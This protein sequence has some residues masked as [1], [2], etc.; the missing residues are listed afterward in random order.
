MSCR[1]LAIIGAVSITLCLGSFAANSG[2]VSVPTAVSLLQAGDADEAEK[3]LQTITARE[4]KNAAAW[5]YLG[6]ARKA[7]KAWDE[8]ITAYR[9]AIE[10]DPTLINPLYNLAAISALKGDTEGAFQWLGKAKATHKADLTGLSQDNDFANVKADPRFASFLPQPEDFKN[11]FVEDV[12]IIHEFDG[13]GANDQFGWIAR[14]LGDIDGDGIADFVTSAPNNAA[15]GENAGAIYVYSSRRGKLLW[16]AN[17]EK[18]D[19]LGLGVECA[20]DT[21]GDGI[22]DVV[23]SSP[24]HGFAHIY[25][26]KDGSTLL[27]VKSESAEPEAFGQ[28]VAG[29]GDVNHD[30]Y[31]DFI[32][33]APPPPNSAPGK[34]IGHAYVYSG[35]DGKLLL[36]LTGEGE[37]DGFGSAVA[38]YSDGKQMFMVAG[39]PKAGPEHKGRVYIY[40]ALSSKPKF[41]IEGDETAGALGGMFLSIIG[42]MDG[43]GIP[44]I[45]ASDWQNSA[46]G[47]STGRIYV[48]SGKNGHRLLML[49]GESAG[50]GFGTCA[51]LAGDVDHDGHADL[52]VGAWQQASGATS[53]GKASLFSGQ[54]GKLLKSYTCKTAGDTFGFDAVG[55]GD[56]DG[57]GSDDL[58][59]TSGWSGIHGFHSG[60]IFLISSGVTRNQQ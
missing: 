18:E 10:L 56:I 38:G 31:S 21:N 7:K 2:E 30:G 26:G 59:I 44:D 52:I 27:T 50:E 4:P 35:K 12:K 55:M 37:G 16:R 54:E 39:A 17:G 51:A 11:P 22:P 19:Q 47:P 29:A 15:G 34:G 1:L 20:G 36:T 23:A 28:H 32:I 3:M 6:N 43:D 53:A 25:S 33:G 49:T 5:R 58:L 13:E 45:Y 57:D 40:D 24:I 8:A 46:K 41:V 48:H 42:D 60:R 9:R 14:K